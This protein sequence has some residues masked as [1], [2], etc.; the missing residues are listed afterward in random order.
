MSVFAMVSPK[1]FQDVA[2]GAQ[3]AYGHMQRKVPKAFKGA[4]GGTQRV[5]AD[6]QGGL[7]RTI[8]G[9][10]VPKPLAQTAEDISGLSM[11]QLGKPGI[12]SRCATLNLP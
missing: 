4:A 3:K 1:V 9:I 7:K 2:E 5:L 8:N 11:L 6:F 10:S 12:C